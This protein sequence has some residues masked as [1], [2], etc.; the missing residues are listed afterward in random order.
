MNNDYLNN[1]AENIEPL[2]P[3]EA[4]HSPVGPD[5]GTFKEVAILSGP[6]VLSFISFSMMGV[7]DTLIAGRI[8]TAEQGAV[9]LGGMLTWS[10]CSLFTG[11]ITVVNTFVAQDHGAGRL[12]H[13]RRHV[14]TG[15]TIVPLFAVL[16]WAVIPFL[17]V[18]VGLVGT[19]PQVAPHLQ[20]Y[21]TIRLLGSLFLFV[22]FTITGFLRGLG[23]MRTP[24]VITIVSN[25]INAGLAWLLALGSLGFPRM[26]VAGAATASVIAIACE[27]GMYVYAYL[28]A[29][30]HRR[31][32]T[33]SWTWPSMP[34]LAEFIKIGLPIGLAWGFE[35]M[36]W[37]AFSIYASTLSE[38]A[39]AA[40]M[41]IF[42][43][44]HFSFMPAAAVGITATTLVGRYL[45]AGRPDLASRSVRASFITAVTFM[46]LTGLT[47]L[48]LRGVLIN[49]FNTD[50]KVMEIGAVLVVIAALFQPFDAMGMILGGAL[51]GA[52]DTRYTFIATLASSITVFIPGVYVLGVV[53]EMGIVGAWIGALCYT[54]ALAS[55]LGA[56]YLGGKWKTMVLTGND[57][58]R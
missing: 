45:G 32:K 19:D 58:V 41:I 43:V 34:E 13:I 25:L 49:A 46:S 39:L 2:Q 14:N 29:E 50:P 20:S 26:G 7:V 38:Y 3:A 35:M 52:G 33:R 44:I 27:T 51:R 55:M 30:N 24:M 4:E 40:H 18:L 12:E 53:F 48:I 47:M 42:T 31:Y 23:D 56:R 1:A 6:L 28:S 37:T 54:A 8:G 21:M 9:G 57:P 16:V 17:P 11:T 10:L 22:N 36:S 5:S 15:L